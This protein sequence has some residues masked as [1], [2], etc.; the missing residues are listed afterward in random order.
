[1]LFHYS[2]DLKKLTLYR[3]AKDNVAGVFAVN[4][5]PIGEIMAY[6]GADRTGSVQVWIEM[7][8]DSPQWVGVSVS[9]SSLFH[10]LIITKTKEGNT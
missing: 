2:P 7:T 9:I 6:P 4:T 3:T 1:M 10:G 5:G 8:P